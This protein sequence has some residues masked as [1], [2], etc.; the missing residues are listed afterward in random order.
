ML[1]GHLPW[2]KKPDVPKDN[3]GW[4]PEGN[5]KVLS[6]FLNDNTKCVIELGSWLGKSTRFI[7]N[8]A[9]NAHVY[10]VDHWSTD[11]SV[12]GNGVGTTEGLEKIG[13]LYETF[14]VNCWDYKDRLTPLRMRT[15]EGL[16]YLKELGV[17]PDMIYIDADHAYSSVMEDI[18][19][20]INNFPKARIVGDDWR[21]EPVREAVEDYAKANGRKAVGRMNCW[22]YEI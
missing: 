20:S 12:Y 21:W 10:A 7:L 8:Q 2:S 15:M 14:L 6:L 4:F 13:T 5:A 17:E 1:G 18:T 16:D 3:H 9:K 11:P 19:K 22:Y